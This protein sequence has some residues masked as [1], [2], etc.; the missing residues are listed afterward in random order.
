MDNWIFEGLIKTVMMLLG[1]GTGYDEARELVE[2]MTEN[3][4]S[5]GEVYRMLQEAAAPR[6]FV[7]KVKIVGVKGRRKG[8]EREESKR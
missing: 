5:T 2:T 8:R 3:D 4:I 6:V 1:D 7:D